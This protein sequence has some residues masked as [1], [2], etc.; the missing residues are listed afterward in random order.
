MPRN[1]TKVGSAIERLTKS[2]CV[3]DTEKVFATERERE[4]ERE[5]ECE[6]W[7]ESQWTWLRVRVYLC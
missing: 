1:D 7:Y 2:V 3:F 4:R 5:C 6:I